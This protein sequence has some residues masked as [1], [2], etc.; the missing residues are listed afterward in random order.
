LGG[1]GSKILQRM[2]NQTKLCR[3]RQESYWKF[4]VLV[5]WTHSQAVETDHKNGNTVCHDAEATEL[6]Q[7]LE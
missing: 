5:P 4:G 6:K 7:L 1:K 3:D 2:I